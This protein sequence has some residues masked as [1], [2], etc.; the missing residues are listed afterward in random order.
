MALL[1]RATIVLLFCALT[2]AR[3]Q[4][5]RELRRSFL[6]LLPAEVAIDASMQRRLEAGEAVTEVLNAADGQVAVVA[7]VATR[8]TVDSLA[9]SV[10]DIATLKRSAYVS[11]VR[12]FSTAPSRDDLHD[13]RVPPADIRDLADC[14]LRDCPIKLTSAE[15]DILQPLARRVR[16]G[17]PSGQ[18]DDAF[19]QL[20][21][22]RVQRY[23]EEGR[24]SAYGLENGRDTPSLF[25]RILADSPYVTTP[26][27]Q[28][29]TYLSR[30]PRHEDRAI[31]SFLY[32]SVE[33]LG[34]KPVVVV[35]HVAL[36]QPG[37]EAR[38]LGVGLLVAGKQVFATHYTDASL[39]LTALVEHEGRRY[40]AY[41][42]RSETDALG[43][44]LGWLKRSIVE[45]RVRNEAG[46]ILS[47]VRQRV[48]GRVRQQ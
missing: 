28:L 32:W 25:E 4:N 42:N 38:S 23:L 44:A 46:S 13:L 9:E 19:R 15:V 35:T 29:A 30:F 6:D 8:A 41:V 34:R 24:A 27:P 22:A 3:A 7:L 45:R 16:A 47:G 10:R 17:E 1:W 48:E 12:R 37:S 5:A 40:L 36:L 21:L 31:E 2:L 14:S 39:S 11:A 26:F 43:G 18:L 20:V 33:S